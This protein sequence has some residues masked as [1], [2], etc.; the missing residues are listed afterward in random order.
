MLEYLL[1]L[2]KQFGIVGTLILGDA[3]VTANIVSPIL[4]IV[5]AITAISEFTIPDFSFAFSTR[6]F[7]L[8]YIV[9]G[10]LGGILGMAC[11]IFIHLIYLLSSLS[12][13]VPFL[14][15]KSLANYPIKA[16]WKN[17]TRSKIL[18]TKKPNQ[19]E[20]ISMVW[21]KHEK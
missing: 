21:R 8:M 18:N 13:G 3:A 2:D 4:V 7:R 17:E 19:E 11:G 12:F 6:T 10:Y 14:S 16:I 9:L 15:F 1:L 5:V 20:N